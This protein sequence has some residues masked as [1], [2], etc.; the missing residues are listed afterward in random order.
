M[1]IFDYDPTGRTVRDFLEKDRYLKTIALGTDPMIE[2]A[3]EQV[4][5]ERKRALGLLPEHSLASAYYESAYQ[6]FAKDLSRR[7]LENLPV[8]PRELRAWQES[9]DYVN[10]LKN[11]VLRFADSEVDRLGLSAREE[12]QGLADSYVELLGSLEDPLQLN[13]IVPPALFD[14]PPLELRASTQA[15]EVFSD[16]RSDASDI[17][18]EGVQEDTLVIAL[19]ALDSS[20]PDLWHGA[21]DALVS[22]NPDR[23]RHATTSCRELITHVLH[24]LAP[25]ASVKGWD[26]V[27]EG[28]FDDKGRPT[29]KARFLFICRHNWQS[30]LAEFVEQDV[31]VQLKLIDQLHPS[32]HGLQRRLS[33]RELD[34]LVKRTGMLLYFLLMIHHSSK[35]QDVDEP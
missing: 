2:R 6:R 29:R 21:N 11:D 20:L 12:L 17:H 25:D 16:P 13:Q 3:L 23:E 26:G 5:T 33:D 10:V 7:E 30:R 31:K 35:E 18:F 24:A 27:E 32:V 34:Y 15:I 8:H 14:A 19:S 4:Q 22:G 28:F 1:S 9:L